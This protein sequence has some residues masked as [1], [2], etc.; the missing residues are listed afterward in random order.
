MGNTVKESVL[1]TISE[2]IKSIMGQKHHELSPKLLSEKA[3][4]SY[5]TLAPILKGERD[6]GVTRLL[7]IA[8]ALHVTPHDLLQNTFTLYTP[9]GL[10]SQKQ[11]LQF[12]VALIT[13]AEFTHCKVYDIKKNLYHTNYLPF[14]VSC[15]EPPFA[16]F[17][18]IKSSLRYTCDKDVS[19]ENVAIY[20]SAISC[21]FVDGRDRLV[22]AGKKEFF[23]FHLEPDWK[24]SYKSVFKNQ[25][26]ILVTINNGYIIS[27]S[28]DQGRTI[29]KK[30][31][32]GLP[33][34]DDAGN[35]WLGAQAIRHAINVKEDLEPRTLLSDRISSLTGSDFALLATEMYKDPWKIYR[36]AA[37]I[38]KE[39]AF[40]EPTS[41]RL[42]HQAFENI[43]ERVKVID[44]AAGIE[45]PLAV[46]GELAYLFK[47]MFPHSRLVANNFIE[48]TDLQLQYSL[49]L[50]ASHNQ[51]SMKK[52]C[53]AQ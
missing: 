15:T 21:E 47:D 48:Q 14:S 42:I 50:L 3:E 12:L 1:K 36:A 10:P 52:L 19:L 40:H 22:A 38:V 13:N 39:F 35:F 28:L 23:D 49:N 43:F 7:A 16:L 51:I 18:K 6:F 27:Y 9:L 20:L 41:K 25:N 11:T 37:A 29:Q 46:S 34:A 4:M 5:S 33:F 30:Q 44:K 8:N 31:G 24:T 53:S 2:N 26:A 17:E 32:Q 45:L